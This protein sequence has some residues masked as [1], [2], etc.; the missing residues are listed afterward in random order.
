[1]E[2]RNCSRAYAA[3][4]SVVILFVASDAH[5]W[6][7]FCNKKPGPINVAFGLVQKTPLGSVQ[8]ETKVRR[9]RG[10]IQSIVATVKQ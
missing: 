5:A 6:V 8:V 9:W 4:L 1:M 10:G 3:A 7:Q 2:N